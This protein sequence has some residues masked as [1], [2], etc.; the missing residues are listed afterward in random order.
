MRLIRSVDY[1]HWRPSITVRRNPAFPCENSL[2]RLAC[3]RDSGRSGSGFGNESTQPSLRGWQMRLSKM[4]LDAAAVAFE[5]VALRLYVRIFDAAL[6]TRRG[7]PSLVLSEWI[8]LFVGR[9]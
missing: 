4:A 8:M 5:R 6:P 9:F 7:G 3:C 2:S 1:S